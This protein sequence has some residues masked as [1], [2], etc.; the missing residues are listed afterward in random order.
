MWLTA[1]ATQKGFAILCIDFKGKNY[2]REAN[3]G[4]HTNKCL[5]GFI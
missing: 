5:I 3:N 4:K 2:L 1:P